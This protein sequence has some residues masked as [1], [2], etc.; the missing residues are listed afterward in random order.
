MPRKFIFY[1]PDGWQLN[2]T[3][4]NWHKVKD[5]HEYHRRRTTPARYYEDMSLDSG[6][7]PDHDDQIC[8][9]GRAVHNSHS[10]SGFYP[11][12]DAN[13]SARYA[14]NKLMECF[15][16]RTLS[17]VGL[18]GAQGFVT[19]FFMA[20]TP[21]KFRAEMVRNMWKFDYRKVAKHFGGVQGNPN[22]P[23][24][25]SLFYDVDYRDV[26]GNESLYHE[27]R[28]N[29]FKT[30]QGIFFRA[31]DQHYEWIEKTGGLS[32]VS[33]RL[34][35][36]QPV[37]RNPYDHSGRHW[38]HGY[39]TGNHEFLDGI[40]K[41]Y[42][43]DLALC[44][45]IEFGYEPKAP[46][47]DWLDKIPHYVAQHVKNMEYHSDENRIPRQGFLPVLQGNPAQCP[48]T[49]YESRD[50]YRQEFWAALNLL[51]KPLT[52]NSVT[53]KLHASVEDVRND[54][55]AR[56]FDKI[57]SSVSYCNVCGGHHQGIGVAQ[58]CYEKRGSKAFELGG[59]FSKI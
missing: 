35:I 29:M 6:F 26:R 21:P 43:K 8:Q 14:A 7:D 58:K 46:Q 27:N 48:K 56:H 32:P 15:Q 2:D 1:T 23:N 22:Y 55:Y 53:F 19:D 30:F 3:G 49:H 4:L 24:V 17:D 45:S 28:I 5:L 16:D 33:T 39:F 40:R 51:K 52:G 11:L 12:A 31:I 9:I 36:V 25:R 20:K 57:Q 41:R 37:N 50:F 34:I 54:S 18:I 10:F 38:S 47:G 13:R 44:V 42:N 59:V